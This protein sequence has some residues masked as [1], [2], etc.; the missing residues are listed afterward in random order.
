MNAK[1]VAGIHWSFWAIE[2][3]ALIWN[4][5]GVTNFLAQMNVD[6]LATM[7]EIRRDGQ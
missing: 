1:T 4:V 2:A 6:A 5:I 7:P 3:V